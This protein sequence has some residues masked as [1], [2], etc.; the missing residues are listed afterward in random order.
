MG[1]PPIQRSVR[2]WR[3][4]L[5][6]ALASSLLVPCARSLNELR[7]LDFRQIGTS[8]TW[9]VTWSSTPSNTYQLQRALSLP[10]NNATSWVPV[11]TIQATGSVATADHLAGPGPQQSFYRIAQ[12]TNGVSTN[13]PA[14]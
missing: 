3:L 10:V 8:N 7:I 11:L 4:V 2:F 1:R 6:I 12:L 13:Q 9:R 14:L 5:L